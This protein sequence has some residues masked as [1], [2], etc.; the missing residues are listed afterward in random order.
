M[1]SPLAPT[2]AGAPERVREQIATR[3]AFLI[4]GLSTAAWAP[5]VP[6]VKERVGLD[7]GALGMLLLC[8]GLGSITAMPIT[9]FL[10]TRIGCRAVIVSSALVVLLVL[11]LLAVFD[12]WLAMAVAIAVFGAALGTLDVAMNIQA[13]IVER[14]SGKAMMS[15][16]HGLYSV[17]GIAGSGAMSLFLATRTVD[18]ALAAGAVSAVCLVLLAV[19]LPGLLSYGDDRAESAPSFAWPKGIVLFIGFLCF[20]CFMVEGAVLDWSAVFLISERNSDVGVAGLGYA[21]FACTMT[22]G[23]L[24]GDRLRMILGERR[25]LM[26]GG[27]LAAAGFLVVILVPSAIANL[28][29][30]LLVG[31]GASNVV[32]VLFSAAG[33]TRAMSPGLAVTA[34]TTLGYLG[35]LAGPALIGWIAQLTELRVAFGFLVVAMVVIAL[36]FRIGRS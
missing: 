36:S 10:T 22:V 5:L 32:P 19:A 14:L 2:L 8:L 30:F 24:S 11:P 3:L 27:L 15:G 34:V 33:R 26:I 16:F 18:P 31:A 28:C 35:I 6:L 25:V 7:A 20:L 4:A 29:G 17:G 1:P 13:I 9:G 23:R 21:A 12:G